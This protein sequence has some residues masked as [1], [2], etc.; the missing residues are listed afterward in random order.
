MH[1]SMAL[2]IRHNKILILFATDL[3]VLGEDNLGLGDT[4]LCLS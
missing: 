2:Q 4:F 1:I 3:L